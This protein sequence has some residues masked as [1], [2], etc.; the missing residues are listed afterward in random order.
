[1]WPGYSDSEHNYTLFSKTLSPFTPRA[2]DSPHWRTSSGH[3]SLG[4]PT[5]RSEAG[6]DSGMSPVSI[7]QSKLSAVSRNRKAKISR[8][9][10]TTNSPAARGSAWICLPPP[11]PPPGKIKKET[12]TPTVSLTTPLPAT[13]W[14][15]SSQGRPTSPTSFPNAAGLSEDHSATS[16]LLR[17]L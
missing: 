5:G 14:L 17:S 10:T 7:L 1:M 11:P 15:I 2:A 8:E 6:G 3:G 16:A 9:Q 12:P 4:E 13:A